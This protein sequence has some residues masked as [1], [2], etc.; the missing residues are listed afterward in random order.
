M[1]S[2]ETR[3]RIHQI[4]EKEFLEKGFK[5]ASLRN[6]VKEA[7]V[8]T[9]AFYGYYKSKED[10]FEALVSPHANYFLSYY[11]D[12]VSSFEALSKEEQISVVSGFGKKYMEDTLKY[13]HEHL[14]GIKL[15]LLASAGTK[16]ET[17]I[18]QLVEK[19]IQSNH[20]FMK[21]LEELGGITPMFHPRFEHTI[22]SGMFNSYFELVIHDVPYDEAKECAQQIYQFYAAG[23][24]GCRNIENGA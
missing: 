5:G 12:V 1:V 15:L 17:F 8:T 22:I 7:G 16:Y 18:H 14:D 9:G 10:L 24:N 19:E 3:D 11:D 20:N 4:A 13:V 23:W 21:V 2:A 6:I